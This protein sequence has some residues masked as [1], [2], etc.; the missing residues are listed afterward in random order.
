MEIYNLS[1]DIPV[2]E[3]EVKSFPSG[4]SEAFNELINKT[5]D[6]AGARSYFGIIKPG[7]AGKTGYYVAAGEKEPGEAEKFNYDTYAIERG[8]YLITKIDDWRSKTNSI[9]CISRALSG[10]PY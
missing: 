4:I 1:N 2:F 8:E 7:K 6:C 3:F 9:K 5:G 10:W